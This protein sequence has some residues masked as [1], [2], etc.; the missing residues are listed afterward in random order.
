MLRSI[1]IA[2]LC[3]ILMIGCEA[4]TRLAPEDAK[5]TLVWVETEVKAG[6]L[7]PDDAML[8]R[9]CPTAVMELTKLRTELKERLDFDDGFKGLIYHATVERYG[10]GLRSEARRRAQQLIASC[11]ALIPLEKLGLF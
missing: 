4:V 10:K 8:A 2:T 1:L 7:Q 9:Q 11:A 5:F 6:R 3:A